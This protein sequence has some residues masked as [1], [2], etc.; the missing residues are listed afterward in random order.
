MDAHAI[1]I[2]VCC[3]GTW[4]GAHDMQFSIMSGTFVLD[5]PAEWED[6]LDEDLLG[7]ASWLSALDD[8][9]SR[10]PRDE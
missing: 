8:T 7:W 9:P 6:G 3:D 10:H 5:G 2:T 1:D 4:S